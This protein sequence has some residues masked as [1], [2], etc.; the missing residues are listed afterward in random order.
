MSRGAGANV[1]SRL[2]TASANRENKGRL[3]RICA[4]V[5]PA[6]QGILQIVKDASGLV[7]L[8]GLRT[9][10]SGVLFLL[11]VAQVSSRSIIS[12][13]PSNGL[14]ENSTECR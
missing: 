8:P 7:D 2:L 5:I 4:D 1:V 9:G 12:W 14:I 3:K 13:A 6:L 10:V 11:D